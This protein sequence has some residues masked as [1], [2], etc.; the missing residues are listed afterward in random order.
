SQLNVSAPGLAVGREERVIHL[1]ILRDRVTLRNV[2]PDDVEILEVALR[3]HFRIVD[4]GPLRPVR[5]FS[6]REVYVAET[7]A[8]IRPGEFRANNA[9]GTDGR[10]E[11]FAEV[12][13]ATR[14]LRYGR[15]FDVIAIYRGFRSQQRLVHLD[16]T[17]H[18][19]CADRIS[20]NGL[21]H[22]R[23]PGEVGRGAAWANLRD[24]FGFERAGGLIN[25][26]VHLAHRVDRVL[27]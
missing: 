16:A 13:F 9:A 12:T 20:G 23:Q 11:I 22:E 17:P 26:V 19:D 21:I 24:A 2:I 1:S 8:L 7:G 4:S 6:G 10:C 14:P 18:L 5:F 3:Q 27:G 25:D 15:Q